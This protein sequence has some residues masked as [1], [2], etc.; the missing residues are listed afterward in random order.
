MNPE[1]HKIEPLPMAEAQSF[2]NGKVPVDSAEFKRLADSAK[3]R[4]FTVSGLARN[5]QLESVQAALGEA[6]A[7]GETLGDFKKR[8]RET[9]LDKGWTGKRAWRVDNIYRT[10]VQTAFQAGRY[11]QMKTVA[12]TRP[13][14]RYVAVADKR[15]RPTHMAL[16]GKIY[17]HDHPFWDQFYPPN[18]FMCRCT[19][20]TM[21]A[22]QMEG[23]GLKAETDMPDLVEP[24]DPKTGQR[25]PARPV[26]PDRGFNGNVG[27][28]WLAGLS[29]ENV[30][31]VTYPA[32]STL[33]RKGQ[34]SEDPC[35]PPLAGL[36][37]RHILQVKDSDILAKSLSKESQVLAFLKEFGLPSIDASKV[38]TIPGGYPVVVDKWLFMDKTSGA[39]KSTWA[40]KGP[41]MRL[42]A[43][44]IQ[45]PF[46]VWWAPVEI[47]KH[48]RLVY[49]LRLIRL[50]TLPE[51]K[52]VGG[53]CS[54]SL[55][56]GRHWH[57][58][59]AFAPK[60]DRSSQAILDYLEK[61]RAGVLLHRETLT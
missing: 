52:D 28:D 5:G 45:N 9:I 35:K 55:I 31:Q 17:P 2:W 25:L 48:K 36:D 38:I 4:A 20:S 42:L 14:W 21:S 23:K 54:F 27:R 56:G 3:T 41:Y 13:Y 22:R 58:A 26:L 11:Q 53:Y 61:Q 37:R 24:I 8:I 10:N 43:R 44:T 40:D 47:G 50:F 32:T 51:S 15:T 7:N 16:N 39:F 18:G 12:K 29:P 46:E 34:F 6:L 33:C 30:T 19:V 59:T 49:S 57:G 60:A 1:L